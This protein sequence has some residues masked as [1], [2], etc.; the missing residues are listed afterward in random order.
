MKLSEIVTHD[1]GHGV[2]NSS[3]DDPEQQCARFGLLHHD[4][5]C[6]VD[7]PVGMH[8]CSTGHKN[9]L[10]G[11]GQYLINQKHAGCAEAGADATSTHCSLGCDVM[12]L[13]RRCYRV[14]QGYAV[15]A[16][17]RAMHVYSCTYSG[18]TNLTRVSPHRPSA[19]KPTQLERCGWKRRECAVDRAGRRFC[20][21]TCSPRRSD[22]E[23]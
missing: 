15:H 9:R 4:H 5:R 12:E 10:P 2:G 23:S 21:Y 20:M 19:R 14:T 8:I 13:R 3:R 6:T 1:H 18:R 16:V 17:A 22:A 11:C 7:L